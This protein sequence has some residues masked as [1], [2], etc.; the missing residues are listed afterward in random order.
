MTVL[1][2]GAGKMVEALLTG[3]MKSEDLSSW[4]IYSPSGISAKSLSEKVGARYVSDPK[5]VKKPDWILVGCKPQQLEDLGLS[6]G[7]SFKESLFISLLAAIS[8]EDQ[9]SLLN[10]TKM[11]RVMPNLPVEL[12]AGVVLLSSKSASE[13]LPRFESLFSP[14]GS[15]LAV[16]EEEL[17]E[18]TLLT[19]SG[20]AFFYEFAI[21]L[22]SSFES[23]DRDKREVLVKQVLKGAGMGMGSTLTLPEMRDAVTSKGGVTIAVLEEWRKNHFNDFIKAGINFGKKRI[24][25][26]RETLKKI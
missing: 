13:S 4:I 17:D 5:T 23:L 6:I 3:L 8:E 2:L 24:L 14:L 12:N 10:A 7:D 15:A 16:S 1:V 20:P 21:E 19:G 18:L 26:I 25:E 9:L 22:A 11:I